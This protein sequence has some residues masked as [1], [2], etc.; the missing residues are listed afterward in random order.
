MNSPAQH[1]SHEDAIRAF[2]DAMNV[3]DA[4][5]AVSLTRE[6]VV[7]AFGPNEFRGHAVL[8]ELALQVDEQ[9]SS[10]IV[11]VGFEADGPGSVCVSARRI[12][13]WRHTGETATERDIEAGFSFD[14]DGLI[15]R[16]RLT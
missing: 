13:R 15:A 4:D 1:Q 10:E 8:R 7:I 14:A 2:F 5:A 16:V 11:P 3:Q 9:L 12:D 6:D